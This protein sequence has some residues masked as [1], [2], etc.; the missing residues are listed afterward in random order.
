ML[1]ITKSFQSVL[2]LSTVV[3]VVCLCLAVLII[4]GFQNPI[5]QDIAND[6][7]KDVGHNISDVAIIL[8]I[9]CSL[10]LAWFAKSQI[11]NHRESERVVKEYTDQAYL[12]ALS[13]S[14]RTNDEDISLDFF[15]IARDIFPEIKKADIRS[16]KETEEELGVEELTV[17]DK[18][19]GDYTFDLVS[20]K[21]SGEYKFVIKCFEKKVNSD[22]FEECCKRASKELKK[23]GSDIFRLVCLAENFD[24]KIL[25][26]YEEIRE[27]GEF[28]VDLI[29]Y[30]EKG[31]GILK[32]S[33]KSV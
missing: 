21:I 20:E 31:F 28:P 23:T 12:V 27:T 15:N 30:N 29:L 5:L 6:P 16:V 3:V 33:D 14:G 4:L 7:E 13:V 8:A 10:L 2:G 32:I 9:L 1:L 19:K 24:S 17:E 18:K 26:R 11:K 22:D 25:K